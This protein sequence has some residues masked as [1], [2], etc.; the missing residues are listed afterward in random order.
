GGDSLSPVP[1]RRRPTRGRGFLKTKGGGDL[2]G[3]RVDG[4]DLLFQVSHHVARERP[5]VYVERH[6][7]CDVLDGSW[8]VGDAVEEGLP[9]VPADLG[10]PEAHSPDH[11]GEGAQVPHDV[12][13]R[14]VE[15][16]LRAVERATDAP[17]P[18]EVGGR[19]VDPLD[20][21]L[22][23]EQGIAALPERGE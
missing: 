22:V 20:D 23:V 1:F 12:P 19:F 21:R 11:A 4:S 15:L 7:R 18:A 17:N 8:I 6:Q 13:D 5:E 16:A 10:V 3:A 9:E 14:D 2:P